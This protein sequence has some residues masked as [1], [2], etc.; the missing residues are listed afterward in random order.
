MRIEIAADG[1][2]A[3]PGRPVVGVTPDLDAPERWRVT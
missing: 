1:P 2:I 3:P